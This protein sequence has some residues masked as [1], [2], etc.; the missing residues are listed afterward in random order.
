MHIK[1]RG[2]TAFLYRS[3]WVAKGATGNSHGYAVQTY[4]GGMPKD[5]ACIPAALTE[6]LTAAELDFV[7]LRICRPA[8]EAA[9]HAR[10]EAERRDADPLWR[11]VEARRLVDEAVERSQHQRVPRDSWQ[12]IAD[13]LSRLNVFGATAPRPLAEPADPLFVALTAMRAAATAVRDGA[14]GSAPT[15][16]ARTTRA[17][18]LWAQIAAEVDGTANDSL[19]S[20]LQ[21]RGFVKRRKG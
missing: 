4:V 11:L 12:H 10:Q 5:A 20:A 21:S 2:R 9:S 13:S 8:R 14:V 18:A 16:G 15:T 17:Y 6:K 3:H 1:R 19:L 7:E